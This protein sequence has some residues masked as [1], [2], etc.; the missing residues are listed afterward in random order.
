MK[1]ILKCCR[2][3]SILFLYV[4]VTGCAYLE[5]RR[6]DLTDVAHVNGTACGTGIAVN[7]GP[8]LVGFYEILG[9]T[10]RGGTRA[11]L[12]LGGYQQNKEDGEILGVIV[13]MDFATNLSYKDNFY[14]EHSPGWGSVGF[15]M[16]LIFGIGARVDVVEAL[17]FILGIFTIDLLNDDSS[18][19][20]DEEKSDE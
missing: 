20:E 13:P 4:T 18:F 1:T 17:D 6:Q 5:D 7:V 11:K 10:R 3:T 14:K 15:D 2:I 16:G 9:F 12:G 19:K 8:A